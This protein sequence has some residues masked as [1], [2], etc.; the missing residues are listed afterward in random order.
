MKISLAFTLALVATV[1]VSTVY[2]DG[3]ENKVGPRLRESRPLA[4]SGRG[5]RD[6]AT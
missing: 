6:H 5:A 1:S 3:L 2:R 4:P